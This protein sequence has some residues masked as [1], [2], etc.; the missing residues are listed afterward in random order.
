MLADRDTNNFPCKRM[1]SSGCSNW[2]CDEANTAKTQRRQICDVRGC[3]SVHRHLLCLWHS[4]S[5]TGHHQGQYGESETRC[6]HVMGLTLNQKIPG[7][8]NFGVKDIPAS[9]NVSHL[10]QRMRQYYVVLANRKPSLSDWMASWPG[11]RVMDASASRAEC[12]VCIQEH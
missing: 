6:I 4:S 7:F 10:E 3:C 2:T 1:G 12:F 11:S 9:D 8:G 5:T